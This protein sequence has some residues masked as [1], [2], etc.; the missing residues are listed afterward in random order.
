MAVDL[1][2]APKRKR[3]AG[4]RCCEPIVYPDVE[5]DQAIRV[6]DRFAAAHAGRPL[7]LRGELQID[8]H[9]S[10]YID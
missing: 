1:E 7:L 10:T 5:R 9:Q 6:D 3:A 2:L 8:S 4:V